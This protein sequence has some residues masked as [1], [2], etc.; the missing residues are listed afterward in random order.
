VPGQNEKKR[1]IREV[2]S[3]RKY[4]CVFALQFT[5]KKLTDCSRYFVRYTPPRLPGYYLPGNKILKGTI[6]LSIKL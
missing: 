2:E 6:R 1:K 4:S 5:L 3:F